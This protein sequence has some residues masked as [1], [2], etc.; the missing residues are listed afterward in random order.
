M[1]RTICILLTL[2]LFVSLCACGEKPVNGE[3]NPGVT[4]VPSQT[5][6][7]PETQAD[8]T[9]DGSFKRI[10]IGFSGVDLPVPPYEEDGVVYADLAGFAGYFGGTVSYSEDKTVAFV[11]FTD[12]DAKYQIITF[13][14]GNT[15]ANATNLAGGTT[16]TLT[17]AAAPKATDS[18]FDIGAVDFA[19]AIG[20]TCEMNGG[21]LQING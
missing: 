8:T 4:T 15:E 7:A 12:A 20:Y 10:V 5:D 6:N 16:D 2:V 19:T 3:N 13:E 11:N 21:V 17:L 9:D 1:K 18:G 14:A